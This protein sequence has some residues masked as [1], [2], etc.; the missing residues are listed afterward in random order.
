MS[1]QLGA[2]EVRECK[3]QNFQ[4]CDLVFSGLDTDVAGDI[5]RLQNLS[6]FT[7]SYFD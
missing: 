7:M 6:V 3:A 1:K 4:D 2:L 5:G